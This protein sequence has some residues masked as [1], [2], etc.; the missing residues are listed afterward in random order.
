MGQEEYV[1]VYAQAAYARDGGNQSGGEETTFAH[2]SWTRD[3]G[4]IN[5]GWYNGEYTAHDPL[6]GEEIFVYGPTHN[7]APE[8]I[9]AHI[10]QYSNLNS[11]FDAWEGRVGL[12][13]RTG[14]IAVVS[15]VGCASE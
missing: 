6:T 11:L 3:G 12:A 9:V 8:A 10:D 15:A 1:E 14:W 7:M 13:V 5:S 2:V 4:F